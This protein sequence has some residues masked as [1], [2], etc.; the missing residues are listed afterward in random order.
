MNALVNAPV[1]PQTEWLLH[2]RP[3]G[4][5]LGPNIIREEE[6]V[7]PRHGAVETEAVR[8]LLSSDNDEDAGAT[9]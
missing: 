8:A 9:Q 6:L 7:P 2:A 3:V 1:D 4:L 5:V